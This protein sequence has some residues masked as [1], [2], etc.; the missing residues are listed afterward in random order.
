[1]GS[2]YSQWA[3]R[4]QINENRI[5]SKYFKNISIHVEGKTNKLLPYT[6]IKVNLTWFSNLIF[7][8]Y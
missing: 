3:G 8:K 6:N 2:R 5:Y 4:F 1:M 7:K